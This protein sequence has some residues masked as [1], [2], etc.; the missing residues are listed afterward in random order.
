MTLRH[1][2]AE[3]HTISIRK[4]DQVKIIAGRDAGKSGRVLSIN[5][6]KNTVV[7]E[8]AS[9]IKRHTRPNPGKNIKGGI[10]EKEGPVNVSNVMIVCPSCGKHARMGHTTLPD[11]KKVRSCRRCGTTLDK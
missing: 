10:V 2:R 9:I 1:E 8:H 5:A 3:R 7:V 4:G 11:G 6:K